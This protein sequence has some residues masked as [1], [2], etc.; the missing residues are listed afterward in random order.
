MSFG[1]VFSEA[2]DGE[3]IRTQLIRVREHMLA[4]ARQ[5]RWLSVERLCAELEAIW[6][7]RF[8]AESVGAD[9]RHLRKR[10]HGSHQVERR[11]ANGQNYSEFRLALPEAVQGE[12]LAIPAQHYR[13]T[14]Q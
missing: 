1:P 2:R 6:Q 4:A 10:E 5:G 7:V 11:R 13:E 14:S 12:L 3:R 9:L 8:P